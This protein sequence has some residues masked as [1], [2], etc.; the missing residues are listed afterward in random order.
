[1]QT[2]F[3][4]LKK[5]TGINER[6]LQCFIKPISKTQPE[7]FCMIMSIVYTFSPTRAAL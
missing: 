2:K 1:M 7:K 5:R 3:H 6:F 4:G